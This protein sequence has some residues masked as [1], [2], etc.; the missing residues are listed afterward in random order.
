MRNL[1]HFLFVF[2]L[3]LGP[4]FGLLD[5]AIVVPLVILPFLLQRSLQQN[6]VVF[7]RGFRIMAAIVAFLFCYQLL[8][9]LFSGVFEVEAA[10]RLLRALISIGLVALLLGGD[11]SKSWDYWV[12]LVVAVL[13]VHS[14]LV[15]LGATFPA[16]NSF[17]AVMM[18]AERVRAYRSSGLMA[19]FDVAGV[20][21]ILGLMLVVFFHRMYLSKVFVFALVLIFVSATAFES[22]VSLAITLLI[23]V[24]W[25]LRMLFD[26]QLAF[27]IKLPLLAASVTV[28]MGVLY[29]FLLI[30]SATFSVD[31][32]FLND[33]SSNIVSRF[34]A[35][36]SAESAISSMFFLP[37]SLPSLIFGV[38]AEP[39]TSD[40]GYVREIY[41]YGLLGLALAIS[42]HVVLIIK[43]G[44][45]HLGAN[46][47]QNS[48]WLIGCVSAL[49]LLLSFKNNYVFVRGV[50]PSFLLIV[51]AL[52]YGQVGV[53]WSRSRVPSR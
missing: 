27:V 9:Q 36:D 28:L 50:F 1:L 19:G 38:G 11:L 53:L 47:Q 43:G 7:S 4:R 41:R 39:G 8:V 52:R 20:L 49:L 16:L 44:S 14:I 15:I 25:V 18:D 33:E 5:T 13:A 24:A 51:G 45:A 10:G 21:S 37:H 26:R 30:L 46:F 32:F 23:M 34:A 22:R 29:Y 2:F 35:Y 48:F 3:I 31:F 42:A 12:K 6:C 40:V 17:L